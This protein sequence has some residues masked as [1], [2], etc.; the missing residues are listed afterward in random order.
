[1]TKPKRVTPFKQKAKGGW[2]NSGKKE[3]K[4]SPSISGILEVDSQNI[5]KQIDIMTAEQLGHMKQMAG[6]NALKLFNKLLEAL[7]ERIPKMTD[8]TLATSLLAVWDKVGGGKK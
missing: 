7:A 8:E 3:G 6:Q 2:K 1:M 4:K 5:I